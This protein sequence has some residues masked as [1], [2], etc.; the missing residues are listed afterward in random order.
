MTCAWSTCP[1]VVTDRK[2][3]EAHAERCRAYSRKFRDSL[4]K[5]ERARRYRDAQLR[6]LYGISLDEYEEMLLSQRGLCKICELPE[7]H[8]K[9]GKVCA[10]SVDHDHKTGVV[11]GLLCN[12][13]NRALGLFGEN[14][15]V[16]ESARRYLGLIT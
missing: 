10:L 12:N 7:R 2:Y 6:T 5:E 13:C 16:L 4:S 15:S 9:R 11:R 14:A 8:M 1:E 3:C